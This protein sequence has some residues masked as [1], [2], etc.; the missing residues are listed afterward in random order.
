[1]VGFFLKCVAK[2]AL[3]AVIK[4]VPF[5]NVALAIAR[6]VNEAWDR[7]NRLEEIQAL[8]QSSKKELRDEVAAIVEELAANQPAPVRETLTAYLTQVP[9]AVQQSLRREADPTG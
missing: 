1:M 6:D 4:A 7:Q 8:V 3:K 9:A 5:G 2:S